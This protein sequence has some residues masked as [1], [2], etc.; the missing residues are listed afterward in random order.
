M[1]FS[2][3]TTVALP[4]RMRLSSA[5]AWTGM[6]SIVIFRTFASSQTPITRIKHLERLGGVFLTTPVP[7]LAHPHSDG[8]VR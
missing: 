5:M 2:P 8:C 7:L 4:S 6:S 3:R 1:S